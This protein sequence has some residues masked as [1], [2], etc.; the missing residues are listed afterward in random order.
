[1]GSLRNPVGPLPSSIYWRRRAILVSVVVLAALLITWA[2]TAGGDA[3]G[4]EGAAGSDADAR[5]PVPSITPGPSSSGPAISRAP[6]GRDEPDDEDAGDEEPAGRGSGSADPE[7]SDAT[8]SDAPVVV[9]SDDVLPAGSGLEACAASAVEWR[10]RGTR[11]TY[12]TDATPTLELTVRNT[13]D[14]DCAIDLG[15]ERVVLTITPEDDQ[16]AYWSSGHCPEDPG[17]LAYRVPAGTAVTH[18]LRWD[19]G[20]SAPKCGTPPAGKAGPGR[21]LAEAESPG[22][23]AV[24]ASFTLTDE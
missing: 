6:G 22:L 3:G 21:Y 16:D 5:S 12:P 8:A 20:A 4:G 13:S 14:A 19:R 15:P 17:S 18:T 10:L 2:V 1:M 11:E 7:E 9:G 23:P 24:R